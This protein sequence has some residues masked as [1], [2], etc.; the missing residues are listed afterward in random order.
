MIILTVRPRSQVALEVFVKLYGSLNR[1]IQKHNRSKRI[2]IE[3]WLPWYSI[4]VSVR[5][6]HKGG[7]ALNFSTLLSD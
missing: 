3:G 6:F 1:Y 5:R 2:K 7:S 4:E